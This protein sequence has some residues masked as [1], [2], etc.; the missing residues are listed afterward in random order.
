MCV[1]V[2]VSSYSVSIL[3]CSAVYL[4]LLQKKRNKALVNTLKGFLFS[5]KAKMKGSLTHTLLGLLSGF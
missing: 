2:C 5:E 3:P 1:C 4:K